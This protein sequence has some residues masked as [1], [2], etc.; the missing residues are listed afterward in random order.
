MRRKAATISSSTNAATSTATARTYVDNAEGQNPST[1]AND[2][3]DLLEIQASKIK[4]PFLPYIKHWE[5]SLALYADKNFILNGIRHGVNIGYKGPKHYRVSV[6]WPSV[7][8]YKHA[9][10]ESLHT[11]LSHGR[12]LGPFTQP[13]YEHFVGSPMGV[14]QKKRSQKFR[15]INDLSWPP[16]ESINDFI[17]RSDYSLQYVT[18]DDIVSSVSKCKKGAF[19]SKTDLADAFKQILV[20]KEDWGLLGCTLHDEVSGKLLYFVSCT[21]AFGLRSSPCLFNKYADA[22]EYIMRQNKVSNVAHYLDDY[23][24][25]HD[26]R[27]ICQTNLDIMLQTCNSLGFT[28][29][30]SKIVPPSTRIEILG[31]VIDT[32]LQQLQISTG[33]LAEIISELKLW[34]GKVNTT[35]RKL[36]SIVGKLVFVSKVVRCGRTFTRR[37]I[38]LSKKAK[39]LHHRLRLNKAAR[40]DIQWWLDY[41]PLWNGVSYFPDASWT[42]NTVVNFWTDASDI[43]LGATYSTSWFYI[44]YSKDYWWTSH[45][46]AWRELYAVLVAAATWRNQLRGKRL[47]FHCDNAC[48]VSI[49]NS[50][51]SKEPR[52][53][54]LIRELFFISAYH[55]FE[56]HAVYLSSREN[57]YAD[58]LSRGDIHK[59][60]AIAPEMD[61]FMTKP[62]LI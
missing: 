62:Y 20:R 12:M 33:R 51:T 5:T 55:G 17:C 54:E 41:L 48:V 15:V 29:Q 3:G 49:L 10:L 9:V 27:A 8:K 30:S 38:D 11:D 37:L 47:L 23:V 16:G 42:S 58:A 13:P 50:G 57:C 59:F 1:D 31:I 53:M 26:D 40:L 46:I 45:T 39:H 34:Q 56:W 28:V 36:L 43:G 32:K 35:K 18:I 24:T 21:L 25:W 6:N 60:F 22:L 52:M 14:F 61:K 19:L 2:V 7:K 44:N 4:S